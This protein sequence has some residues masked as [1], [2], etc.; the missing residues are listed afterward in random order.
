M[1]G[2]VVLDLTIEEAREIKRAIA[3]LPIFYLSEPLYRLLE[4]LD[5]AE[6][7]LTSEE[8]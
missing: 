2:R 8:G 7:N 3:S 1:S 5:R 6:E 4:K